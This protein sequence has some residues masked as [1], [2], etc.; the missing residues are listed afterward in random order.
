MNI[1]IVGSVAENVKRLLFKDSSKKIVVSP[2]NPGIKKLLN[3][4]KFLL[5][6]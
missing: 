6:I 4:E 2:G 3:V 1:L 5:T